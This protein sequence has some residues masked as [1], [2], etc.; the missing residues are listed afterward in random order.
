M[1]HIQWLHDYCPDKIVEVD[2]ETGR[3]I[4]LPDD[5]PDMEGIQISLDSGSGR[6]FLLEPKQKPPTK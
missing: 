4:P 2:Q 5:S 3:E 1:N 6:L